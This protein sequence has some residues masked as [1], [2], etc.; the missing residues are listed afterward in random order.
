MESRLMTKDSL[1]RYLAEEAFIIHTDA[2]AD[3]EWVVRDA[4]LGFKLPVKFDNV[5][6][7]LSILRAFETSIYVNTKVWMS[8]YLS[9]AMH[10]GDTSTI[11]KLI[12][13]IVHVVSD[14]L[15]DLR[16]VK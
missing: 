6:R 4:Y 7:S 15:Y 5:E 11:D 8:S 9:E 1:E 13:D 12:A 10:V 2:L 14:Q 3:S 16:C